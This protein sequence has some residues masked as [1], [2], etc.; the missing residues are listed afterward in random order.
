VSEQQSFE[1]HAFEDPG[2]LFRPTP[3]WSWNADLSVDEVRRQVREMAARRWGGFF[4]HT[5][6][7]LV[8]PYLSTDFFDL[9]RASVEEAK[10]TGLKAWIYDEDKWPSGYAGGLVPEESVE[11]RLKGIHLTKADEATP[12]EEVLTRTEYEGT[13]YAI[14]AKTGSLGDPWFNYAS[15][16][17]LMNKQTVERFLEIT[18]EAYRSAVGE[19]FGKTVPGVFTDEPCFLFFGFRGVF[20]PWTPA[21]PAY[22]RER[23]GYELTSSLASL[24]LP[25]GDYG[26]VRYDFFDA[27]T[28][29]FKESFTQTYES[30]ATRHGLIFTG[31]F[32]SEDSLERQTQ[33]IGAA[34][35]HYEHMTWP[36]IDKLERHV[37]EHI[38]CKQVSSVADQ[39]GKE[40]TF[41]ET[42]GG[43]GQHLSFTDR[44]WIYNWEAALG[45]NVANPHL[46]LYTMSGERKRDFPANLFYQQPWWEFEDTV[47]DYFGRVSYAL[48]RGRR[49]VDI[50]VLHP[51]GS[52]WALYDVLAYQ[53]D[54]ESPIK[55]YD[56]HLESLTRSLLD[57]QLDF[58][59]GD[60]II[61]E[62]HASIE[63]PT[64]EAPPRPTL[65]IGHS[66][67][68][69]VVVPASVTWR[70][71]TL[72][73][74][75]RFAE[76]GGHVVLTRPLPRF[77]DMRVEIDLSSQLSG[78]VVADSVGHAI[79]AIGRVSPSPVRLRRTDLG[80]PA[81]SIRIHRRLLPD[82]SEL[83]FLAN[84]DR[85]A[86][87][88][89]ELTVR[90]VPRGAGANPGNGHPLMEELDCRTGT[91]LPVEARRDHA[92]P[93]GRTVGGTHPNATFATVF[94]PGEAHLYRIS[95]AA[96]GGAGTADA[97]RSHVT[98]T[99]SPLLVPL[100]SWTLE[101]EDQNI[102][103]I[104]EVTLR[105][106][107]REVAR[108]APLHLLWD[109]HFLSLEDGT[110]FEAEYEFYLDSQP[111]GGLGLIVE[112]L[113]NLD[114]A[115]LNE[116]PIRVTE[117]RRAFMD[118]G[119]EDVAVSDLARPGWNTLR[120]SGRKFNNI[121]SGARGVGFHRRVPAEIAS[122]YRPTELEAV[123]LTGSFSVASRQGRT[124]WVGAE[125]AEA[126]HIR[127]PLSLTEQ[128]HPFYAG[129][130]TLTTSI[131]PTK[132]GTTAPGSAY[133]E[134]EDVRVPAVDVHVDGALLG[135]L[136][137]PPWKLTLPES[138]L[139]GARHELRLRMP[140]D[141]FNLLGPNW[142]TSGLPTM[143]GPDAFRRTEPWT[144][145]RAFLP[146]GIGAARVVVESARRDDQREG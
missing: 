85:N 95:P 141:L 52:A 134:L 84:A 126:Q 20:L 103:P 54:R 120:I 16:V 93:G 73:L 91:L 53:E 66:S 92:A 122:D 127:L 9:V 143:T 75:R 138:L 25:V 129:T 76:A 86:R 97:D 133:L 98:S 7:G 13:R 104:D 87:I 26:R 135:R 124:F 22:F 57:N 144:R 33:W 115:W 14:C 65:R 114:G 49:A 23:H 32:M 80:T 2:P 18:V 78:S 41:C 56:R 48:S 139:D 47:N 28:R 101:F 64:A 24:F 125:W 117:A 45:I 36:G 50:L 111:A 100:D 119:F 121:T 123:Y 83:L 15:Y 58:H 11:H 82:G 43:G 94:E 29:L 108:Q 31:H 88:P 74:L 55:P 107:G 51:I 59:F 137:W 142:K 39:L 140:T 116:Q 146:M 37:D 42:F 67:Y 69:T 35:P 27:A 21:L 19:E 131:P 38:T 61:M 6:V 17:D 96:A 10:E 72:E 3:L 110:P 12:D 44:R 40:R 71:S 77:Q 60:E 113:S 90:D 63:A 5:R 118:P 89:V 62:R 128:G 1:Q 46:A 112:R 8:T 4:M 81:S 34:M 79:A 145:E 109:E 136:R 102:L 106:E 30:Y 105:V 130:F 132:A 99:A 68:A 70:A